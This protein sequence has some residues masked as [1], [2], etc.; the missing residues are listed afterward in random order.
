MD[1]APSSA[2]ERIPVLAF[3]TPFVGL[4]ASATTTNRSAITT[5]TVLCAIF[6]GAETEA[7][8]VK[9]AVSA[10][11]EYRIIHNSQPE[12]SD[13][14]EQA[15]D[16]W[17]S[18]SELSLSYEGMCEDLDTALTDLYGA[19]AELDDIT[20]LLDN[21]KKRDYEYADV[22]DAG[23]SEKISSVRDKIAAFSKALEDVQ[24]ELQ[25]FLDEVAERI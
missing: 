15:W 10:V 13:A 5:I 14:L 6:E 18:E 9:E 19:Q 21:M 4:L 7:A 12:T 23:Y 11:P 17:S 8:K 2:T 1:A 25:T 3:T 22:V 16:S 20:E 24:V